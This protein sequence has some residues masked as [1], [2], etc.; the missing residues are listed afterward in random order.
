MPPDGHEFPVHY[1]ENI[2]RV[3]TSSKSL[4]VPNSK[5]FNNQNLE[6]TR[7]TSLPCST[8]SYKH[9]LWRND[10]KSERSVR[11]K[12]AMFSTV[13]DSQPSA[14]SA[15]S[16]PQFKKL[17]KFKSSDDVSSSLP[18]TNSPK[19]KSISA[20]KPTSPIK[21][22]LLPYHSLLDVTTDFGGE[23]IKQNSTR[24][25]STTDLSSV[26]NY[27]IDQEKME[28]STLPRK[29]EQKSN[30]NGRIGHTPS[31]TRAVSF[32]G[33]T[34]LHSRSQSL[35][36]VG[37]RAQLFNSKSTEE[38]R[39]S[40][41][42]HLIEQRKKSM[43]KLRGLVIPEKVLEVP[44]PKLVVD[45]PEIQS[46]DCPIP[47]VSDKMQNKVSYFSETHMA[48]KIYST[49]SSKTIPVMPVPP[50]RAESSTYDLPKYSPAF[51]RKSLALYYGAPS[52]VSSVSSSLSSSREELRSC[53]NDTSKLNAVPVARNVTPSRNPLSSPHNY[54][55]PKSLESIAS[56][57][58]SDLSFEYASSASSPSSRIHP[59]LSNKS[60]PVGTKPEV[61]AGGGEEE[62]D[63]D[64][65]VSSSRSSVSHGYTPPH[66]PM[67]SYLRHD[68]QNT[69]SGMV[70]KRTL[71]S[72]TTA[73]TSSNGS[74][75]TSGSQAS[76]SSNSSVDSRR[77]LKPQS[78]EA[79][80]RKNVLSSAKYSC[81]LDVKS[82]LTPVYNNNME[83]NEYPNCTAEEV[84]NNNT[85]PKSVSPVT[86]IENVVVD[87][88]DFFDEKDGAKD[89]EIT[90]VEEVS[91]TPDSLPDDNL[92]SIG[93]SLSPIAKELFLEK[94][95]TTD[96][97]TSYPTEDSSLAT[98]NS[99]SPDEPDSTSAKDSVDS[100]DSNKSLQ[101]SNEWEDKDSSPSPKQ[102]HENG[103]SKYPE[104]RLP[105][106]MK[107]SPT[108]KSISVNS[109]K[110]VFEK[111]D[112]F[113][114]S[115]GRL[116][117]NGLTVNT[118]IQHPRVSSIDSTTSDDSYIPMPNTPFGSIS[119]LQ[120]EQQF[121]SITSLASSTSLI[122]QQ[123]NSVEE[124]LLHY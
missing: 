85:V 82:S 20:P 22:G 8:D 122:S 24:T 91:E 67:P 103:I 41:L 108:Q 61:R 71:S 57:S 36:D 116:K 6:V 50:W 38:A 73:S 106:A 112:T 45:L 5:S 102:P 64:S 107:L 11:D 123:V 60:N 52:S 114:V 42:N 90:L 98:I 124:L 121:G 10:E 70:L 13:N 79:I 21:K 31:L 105:R 40:S 1:E 93:E 56:P 115:N 77:V 68:S 15:T 27:E 100:F 83:C 99:I 55:E 4:T 119:N 25:Q 118:S 9:A 97:V 48:D 80:N 69:H 12:I 109:I 101:S 76:C 28:C 34:K 62:S 92:E 29:H 53:F 14:I 16:Q 74:T 95:D 19:V 49:A 51:K 86:I 18:L 88:E 117:N 110:K 78:V 54:S 120:K 39:R 33:T 43:S 111:V 63:N 47:S 35:T 104:S 32:S 44:T 65:A 94:I 7:K 81:G 2:K 75:L 58:M 37:A 23:L 89:Q 113:S 26:D 30:S 72:E 66:S 3:T 46:K 96:S 59:E 17:N 87:P 84:H